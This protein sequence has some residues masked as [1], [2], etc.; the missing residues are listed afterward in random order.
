MTAAGRPRRTL[1]TV[2]RPAHVG[3]S[4]VAATAVYQGSAAAAGSTIRVAA[5]GAR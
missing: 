5:V 2:P 3:T 4:G 1:P